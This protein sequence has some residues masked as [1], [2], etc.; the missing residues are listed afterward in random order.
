MKYDL[1][2]K[3]VSNNANESESVVP[4]IGIP[5]K[6]GKS[7]STVKTAKTISKADSDKSESSEIV[8]ETSIESESKI[9]DHD[10]DHDPS[11]DPIVGSDLQVD[12]RLPPKKSRKVSELKEQKILLKQYEEDNL[13]PVYYPNQSKNIVNLEELRN[14]LPEYKIIAEKPEYISKDEKEVGVT[15][16]GNQVQTRYFDENLYGVFYQKASKASKDNPAPTLYKI[17]DNGEIRVDDDD[18]GHYIAYIINAYA[19]D[20][21]KLKNVRFNNQG[22][23]QVIDMKKAM[24]FRA[25]NIL[26][27]A[28]FQQ[29]KALTDAI[30]D[31][32]GK[33]ALVYRDQ[34][35]NKQL[36]VSEQ[37]LQIA[38]FVHSDRVDLDVDLV[39]QPTNLTFDYRLED[40]P[41]GQKPMLE[42]ESY[43]DQKVQRL[44]SDMLL[45]AA[46]KK[47]NLEPDSAQALIETLHRQ[48][49]ITYPRA[50]VEKAE[51][52]PI[53]IEEG[54]KVE[55]FTGTFQERQLLE[56]V[57]ASEN[58][59]NEDK[60][61]IRYGDWVLKTEGGAEITKGRSQILFAGDKE[62][63]LTEEFDIRIAPRG[64]S[65]EELTTELISND[66]G[67]AA[68]RT[69]LLQELKQAG[70]ISSRKDRYIIDNRGLYFVA[71]YNVLKRELTTN[72]EIKN[73]KN[74]TRKMKSIEIAGKMQQ[75]VLAE[76]AAVVNQYKILDREEL[77][78]KV[79]AEAKVII[80]KE[81]DLTELEAN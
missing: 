13:Y 32:L 31:N 58:A 7:N 75:E 11:D 24:R 18:A 69:S 20:N 46:V 44:N 23:L 35:N 8:S 19:M 40:I 63:Y 50:S 77:A 81:A 62:Q 53:K 61:F 43:Q 42:F 60:N 34:G 25:K 49:W 57:E 38:N 51:E 41:D 80:E 27:S 76:Y 67:T 72:G 68:T 26:D 39:D 1:E 64:I 21:L 17:A 79:K 14:N 12:Y 10:D 52:V 73:V 6:S 56:L 55:D 70:I 9:D 3:N 5:S 15:T 29:N 71:A 45:R 30:R 59:Y 48:E 74:L 16:K 4:D 2:K 36:N 33:N 66:I 54:K 22:E 78:R 47:L 37:K 28:G 65:P